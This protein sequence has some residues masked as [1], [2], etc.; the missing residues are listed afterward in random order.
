MK[1]LGLDFETA[2]RRNGSI[3]AIG[4]AMLSDGAPSTQIEWRIRPHESLDYMDAICYR[5]H[6]ISHEELRSCDEFPCVWDAMRDLL[7]QADLVTIHNSP[8]D[9]RH[10]RAALALYDLPPIS[11]PY[12]CTLALSRRKLPGLPSHSLNVVAE[13]IGFSFLHHN[14]LEDAAAAA[15]VAHTLGIDPSLIKQFAYP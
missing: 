3:C 12:A 8:F 5:V 11:F 14:A 10:L 9:L 7:L 2:N 4:L 6:G 13:H 15:R 1:L